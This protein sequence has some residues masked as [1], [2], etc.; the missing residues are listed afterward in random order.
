PSPQEPKPIC[1]F[2]RTLF[3]FGSMRSRYGAPYSLTQTAPPAAAA[4]H[5]AVP[6]A[7][8]ILATTVGGPCAAPAAAA[9]QTTAARKLQ[10]RMRMHGHYYG[11]GANTPSSD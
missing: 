2:E 10:E 5:G 9:A 11:V 3:V 4:A 6:G 8:L 7:T 1:V